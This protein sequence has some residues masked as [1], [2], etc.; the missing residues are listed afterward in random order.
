MKTGLTMLASILATLSLFAQ[1]EV[2]MDLQP[3]K[4]VGQGNPFKHSLSFAG[5]ETHKFRRNI[6]SWFSFGQFNPGNKILQIHGVPLK[7]K[8]KTR[9]VDI[10]SFEMTTDSGVVSRTESRAVLRKNESFKL[11][12]PKDSSFFKINNVD[13]LEAR[14][15]MSNDT[16]Q[17]WYLAA[18]NLNGTKDEEQKGVIRCGGKEIRFIKTTCLLRDEPV[19]RNEL[20]SLFTAL[21]IVYLFTY[22]D[23]NIAAVSFKLS[24][25]KF[26]C[27]DDVDSTI[28]TVVASA[29]SLLCFRNDLYY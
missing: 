22:N 20:K 21:H 13:Y 25:K 5:Y 3:Y 7:K 10:F 1:K 4:M 2:D 17:I 15:Q 27:R 12:K 28:K 18:A 9:S 29:A 26:W 11:F 16:A 24:D 14:I 23:Q 6:A 8:Y 19:D